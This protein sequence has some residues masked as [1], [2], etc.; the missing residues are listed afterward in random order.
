MKGILGK[1]VGMTQIYQ[2]SG[3]VVTVT[4]IQ[5]GPCHV[6]QLRT[7]EQDGYSAVQLGYLDKPRRLASRS[8]RGHVAKLGSKRVKRRAN[9]GIE[10]PEKPDCEP[11]RFVREFRGATEGV[12]LGQEITVAELAEVKSVDVTGTSFHSGFLYPAKIPAVPRH[13]RWRL[14][15]FPRRPEQN[16]ICHGF[17]GTSGFLRHFSLSVRSPG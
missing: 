3:K 4:V 17:A 14:R 11:K 12:A 7:P 10:A 8:E 16:R 5:A 9:A 1:K 15:C 13:F 6:L 2:E